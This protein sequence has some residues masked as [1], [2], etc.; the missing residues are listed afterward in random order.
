[1]NS[2][3]GDRSVIYT[4]TVS[5]SLHDRLNRIAASNGGNTGE[6]LAK[7]LALYEVAIDARGQDCRVAILDTNNC[8]KTAIEGL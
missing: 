1:M 6:V 4:L 2:Q 5:G 3:G 7:A 8:I